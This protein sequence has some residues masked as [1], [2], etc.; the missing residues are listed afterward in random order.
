MGFLLGFLFTIYGIIGS[1][2]G[3]AWLCNHVSVWFGLLAPIAFL[4]SFGG[5]IIIGDLLDG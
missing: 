1:V 2:I 3:L 4:V 5:G